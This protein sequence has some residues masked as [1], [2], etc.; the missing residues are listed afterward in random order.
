[1]IYP[2]NNFDRKNLDL[3]FYLVSIFFCERKTNFNWVEQ[4]NGIKFYMKTRHKINSDHSID[5]PFVYISQCIQTLDKMYVY[6]FVHKKKVRICIA[7]QH[8]CRI[9]CT[10]NAYV[11]AC[12]CGIP[13]SF[14]LVAM[15]YF[16]WNSIR[17]L[18]CL[19]C[20]VH[21]AGAQKHLNNMQS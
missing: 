18:V 10:R 21:L 11:C 8:Q 3:S 7:R 5:I 17:L 16:V 4:T 2:T 20:T 12:V 6:K 9:W 15:N 14:N 1:M 13:N 19:L